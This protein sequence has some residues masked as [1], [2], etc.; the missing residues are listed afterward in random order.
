M[1]FR[2]RTRNKLTVIAVAAGLL[3]L[4]ALVVVWM[5]QPSQNSLKGTGSAA[6]QP[7]RLSFELPCTVQL[8]DA[9]TFYAALQ[10]HDRPILSQMLTDKKIIMVHKGT[11]LTII[12]VDAVSKISFGDPPSTQVCYVPSDV[13]SSFQKHAYR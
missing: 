8:A 3:L 5:S 11:A 4:I 13:M 2:R 1:S 7:V 12:P 6:P 10:R 9:S